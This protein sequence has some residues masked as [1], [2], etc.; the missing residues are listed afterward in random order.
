MKKEKYTKEIKRIKINEKENKNP[1]AE[2][3]ND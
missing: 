3:N 2:K 1:R